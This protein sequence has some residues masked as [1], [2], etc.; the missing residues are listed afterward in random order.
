MAEL[1]Q[2]FDAPTVTVEL[3]PI[4]IITIIGNIQLAS[5]QPRVADSAVTRIAIDVARKLQSV[6]PPESATYKTIEIGWLFQYDTGG[7]GEPLSP[8]PEPMDRYE[9]P[10]EARSNDSEVHWHSRKPLRDRFDENFYPGKTFS[11]R[12][13]DEGIDPCYDLPY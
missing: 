13:R 10:E 6:F 4:A 11:E 12:C 8:R 5:R 2:F 7:E 3:P 1:A 9:H